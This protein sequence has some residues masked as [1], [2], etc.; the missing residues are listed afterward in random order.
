LKSIKDVFIIAEQFLSD[1]SDCIRTIIA[2]TETEEAKEL[3]TYAF[4]QKGQMLRPGL[5]YITACAL[6]PDLDKEK[7]KR[8][9][10]YAA[11]IEL[12]HT[13]SLMHDDI[14]DET[15][16]RRGKKSLN[17][18]FG[19]GSALLAGNIFYI[20]AFSLANRYLEKSQVESIL[21]AGTDM[22]LGEILQIANKGKII[23]EEVY[24]DIIR[25]KTA[26]LIKYACKESARIAGMP[27]EWIVKMESMGE[28]LGTIYQLMDDYKDKDVFIEE[29]FDF[30]RNL[31]NQIFEARII[32][33][34]LEDSIFKKAFMEFTANFRKQIGDTSQLYA[35][36]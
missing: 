1:V 21:C 2:N 15:E 27:D 28:H 10:Y 17:K 20:N 26:S 11:A 24:F 32:I 33:E 35:V 13:A 30:E 19:T 25:K 23:S 22:C 12:L 5:V 8:L 4:S 18:A 31:E 7:L 16:E 14:L 9:T 6:N 3:L 36:K 34:S 29:E